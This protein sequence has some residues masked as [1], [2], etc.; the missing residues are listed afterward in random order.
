MRE[1][2]A[3]I[4]EWAKLRNLHKLGTVESQK[5]KTI[6]EFAE[7]II[8]ISKSNID[9]IRDSIGDIYVTL[10]VGNLLL[11]EELDLIK[12]CDMA[13]KNYETVTFN[14]DRAKKNTQLEM[15][16][17]CMR[18][19]IFIGYNP[20][21]IPLTIMYL[22]ALSDLYDLPFE[23]CVESA[24]QEIKDRK[25]KMINGQFVKESDLND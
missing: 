12:L 14:L 20:H 7:L 11:K 1:I 13:S 22:M 25:G 15:A 10:V 21:S 4:V 9:V 24:Y 23:K 6:E 16:I 17:S 2:N 3:L 8:G 18:E 5:V 19:F